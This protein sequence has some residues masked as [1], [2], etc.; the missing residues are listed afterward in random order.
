VCV[1]EWVGV[2]VCLHSGG[3][4][5]GTGL[6][7]LRNSPAVLLSHARL[8]QKNYNDCGLFLIKVRHE[9]SLARRPYCIKPLVVTLSQSPYASSCPGRV[10]CFCV[11]LCICEHPTT[12]LGLFTASFLS[13]N[14][15][16][17]SEGLVPSTSYTQEDIPNVRRNQVTP[18]RLCTS[19]STCLCRVGRPQCGCVRVC[20]CAV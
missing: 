16:C 3:A 6:A 11:S 5:C 1:G 9:Y 20:V 14:I 8:V 4:M 19:P 13:Q 17:L 15:Q 7:A 10:H 2:L 18:G 12:A